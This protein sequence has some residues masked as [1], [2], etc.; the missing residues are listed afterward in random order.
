M[1]SFLFI[2]GFRIFGL[3]YYSAGRNS[4]IFPFRV[5]PVQ[6]S[7]YRE[8]LMLLCATVSGENGC[9]FQEAL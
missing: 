7:K 8:G 6:A 9:G 2:L 4:H 3:N 5:L 1:H